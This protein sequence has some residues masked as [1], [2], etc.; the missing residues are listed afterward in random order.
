VDEATAR[1]SLHLTP[2]MIGFFSRASGLEYPYEQYAQTTVRNFIFGGQEN[3][4]ATTL[5]ESTLHDERADQD[6]PSTNLVSH[7]LGQHW[8]GDY[9]QGRDWANIWLNEGFATYLEALYT[10]HHEGNDAYRFE[11]Y[12]DFQLAE[13]AEDRDSYR[14][15]IVDRHY[16]D[17]FDMV[18]VTTHAKGADVLDM[19]RY[20]VDGREAMSH[21]ASQDEALFRAGI[22]PLRPAGRLSGEQHARLREGV[23]AALAAGIDARGATID[24]FRHVDGVRGSFQDQFLVH[25]RAGEPCGA[26]GTTI[27]KMVVA[28]RG[29][30]VCERCQPRPRRLRPRASRPDGRSRR[31]PG[32]R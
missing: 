29:T 16:N 14:R 8:F 4:S 13:Q 19:L 30:Y 21:P 20:V 6:Y 11:I 9:V 3:V 24:D 26:C 1:R 7:E 12:D 17:P 2:D 28:G 22:H 27:V 32:P 18:D 23:I 25:R 15:P 5:T 31:R 10:Q